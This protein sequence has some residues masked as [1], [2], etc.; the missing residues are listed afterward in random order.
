MPFCIAQ[1]I[2]NWLYVTAVLLLNCQSSTYQN[3]L[4]ISKLR[5]TWRTGLD[6]D[7]DDIPNWVGN[8]VEPKK[9][10]GT[11]RTALQDS[12]FHSAGRASLSNAKCFCR[13]FPLL[14]C[15]YPSPKMNWLLVWN[16]LFQWE[17]S[18]FYVHKFLLCSL[19][20]RY[21]NWILA[22]HKYK[23]MS[24]KNANAQVKVFIDLALHC[25][26]GES[27]FWTVCVGILL[28]SKPDS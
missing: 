14:L 22:S 3:T 24:H 16:K 12:L 15:T 18:K 28:V 4:L 5:G 27:T 26:V 25:T 8:N 23:Y 20:G 1:Q 2:K 17:V 7:P 13:F 10:T 6:L 11:W 19:T 9:L 21:S